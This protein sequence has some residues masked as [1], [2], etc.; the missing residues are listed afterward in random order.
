M[1]ISWRWRKMKTNRCLILFI[2]I[3]LGIGHIGWSAVDDSLKRA[4]QYA[5]MAL[6]GQAASYYESYISEKPNKRDV[7]V[8]LAFAYMKLERYD[9]AVRVLEEEI[10]RFSGVYEAYIL[11]GAVY[12][13]QG[14]LEESADSSRMV[15]AEIEEKLM[16]RQS[17]RRYASRDAQQRA[18][19]KMAKQ[20]KNLG[21]PYFILGLHQK[22][23]GAYPE[24]EGYLRMAQRAGYDAVA[25]NIHLID[26]ELQRKDWLSAR[27]KADAALVLLGRYAELYFL[28]GYAAY[29]M[30]EKFEAEECF[31]LASEIKPYFDEAVKNWAKLLMQDLKY[32]KAQVLLQRVYK[33][34]PYDLQSGF[35]LESAAEKKPSPSIS[36]LT[37]DFVDESE[38]LYRYTFHSNLE[39]V[40]TAVNST[41]MSQLR[42]GNLADA[43]GYLSAFLK[44]HKTSPD[45]NYNLALI[46][47]IRE[48]PGLA[49]EY[50]SR[51]TEL[52]ENYKEAFD[53]IGNVFFKF[54]DYENSLLYYRK[55]MSLDPKDP[56]SHHNLGMVYFSQK[57][58][59]Q[60]EQS[61]RQ[62]IEN[63]KA[64]RK[65]EKKTRRSKKGLQV[66]LTVTTR[67]VAFESHK[68]L[69]NIHMERGNPEEA[70]AEYIIASELEPRDPDV[71]LRIGKIW[72]DRKDDGKA[73]HYFDIYRE[74]GGEEEKIKEITGSGVEK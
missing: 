27:N 24:A 17:A 12:F 2:I 74:L 16:R 5:D 34:K 61:F 69:G 22:K 49:L 6:F 60:A 20:T 65:A 30:E 72:F 71:H 37:K 46:Y 21:V 55:V 28:K 45:L 59:A 31:Q 19:N 14:R 70:L 43:A 33:L 39:F 67:T 23:L 53:L 54:K 62:A 32:E 7:R 1:R 68:A 36:T 9:D 58:Y 10:N 41:F 63:E 52:K 64:S 40:L 29:R 35:L 66:Y 73:K 57:K 3:M 26:I 51:S 56:M 11:L 25:C 13:A 50:A 47:N 42:A 44:L 38:I 18:L 48:L 8:E 4:R 15:A